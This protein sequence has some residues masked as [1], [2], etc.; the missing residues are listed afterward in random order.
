MSVKISKICLMILAILLFSGCVSEKLV[1]V[2]R[3]VEVK[4]PVKCVVP[5]THCDF[6]KPTYTEV[7]KSQRT[8]IEDLRKNSEVCK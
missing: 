8:C 1:Y 5:E 7:I 2:D 6:N 3:P 4:V